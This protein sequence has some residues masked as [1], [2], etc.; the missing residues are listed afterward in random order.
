MTRRFGRPTFFPQLERARGE[1]TRV[2][3]PPERLPPPTPPDAPA[4]GEHRSHLDPRPKTA[5]ADLLKP[6]SSAQESEHPSAFEHWWERIPAMEG[7]LRDWQRKAGNRVDRGGSTHFGITEQTFMQC[8]PVA[9]LPRTR[10]SFEAMTKAQARRIA[11]SLWDLSGA[12]R[13]EDPGVAVL[14]G[15][16]FWGS[17]SVAWARIKQALRERGHDVP[18]TSGL[19]ENSASILNAMTRADAIALLSDAR[20]RHHRGIVAA[21]PSQRVFDAGWEARVE[22]RR[23]QALELS[24]TALGTIE[25]GSTRAVPALGP[26]AQTPLRLESERSPPHAEERSAP[27]RKATLDTALEACQSPPLPYAP[28]RVRTQRHGATLSE[29][30]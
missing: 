3:V 27:S 11:K 22:Q 30:A 20:H 21:D 15:D 26:D 18:E 2:H 19:G 13:L 25:V 28:S 7:K 8:A 10:E 16:W 5:F 17:N 24:G 23:L 12:D 9:G 1:T 6:S 4:E 14:V 29:W